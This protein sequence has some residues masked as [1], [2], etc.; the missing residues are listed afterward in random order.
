MNCLEY[1][2]TEF[3]DKRCDTILYNGDHVICY[4]EANDFFY[5][6][7]LLMAHSLVDFGHY[8]D[9]FEYGLEHIISSF[10]L[11]GPSALKFEEYYR[12]K[13]RIYSMS[14]AQK[15]S[16]SWAGKDIIATDPVNSPA[17]Y[18]GINNVYETVKVIIAWGLDKDYFLGNV[19]KYVSRA[20]KKDPNKYLEDLKK[21]QWY[22]NKRIELLE[23]KGEQ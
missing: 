6:N 17:H 11:V 4:N 13:E 2:L 7:D 10:D 19:I 1:A 18:G 9:I 14:Q 3:I 12:Y 5:D 21:A 8:M 15:P 23:Q 20:G 16:A 22:L